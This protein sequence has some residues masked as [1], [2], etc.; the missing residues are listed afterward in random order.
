MAEVGRYNSSVRTRST[1]AVP[2]SR[3]ELT[4]LFEHLE[5]ELDAPNSFSARQARNHGT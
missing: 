2:A 4:G 5:Q 1:I 3:A